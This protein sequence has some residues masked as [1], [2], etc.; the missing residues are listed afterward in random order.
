M[1]IEMAYEALTE[2]LISFL[3][4]K[5]QKTT[6]AE[7]EWS[8]YIVDAAV[9]VTSAGLLVGVAGLLVEHR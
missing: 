5:G 3:T 2:C 6:R 9:D 1:E 4:T 8:A 7:Q